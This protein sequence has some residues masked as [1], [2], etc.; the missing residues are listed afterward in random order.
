MECP[1]PQHGGVKTRKL[2]A[3]LCLAAIAD[4]ASA[5][6]L[7]QVDAPARAAQAFEVVRSVLQHPAR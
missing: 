2:V 6:A 5:Y 4:G 3:Q 7:A 1:C